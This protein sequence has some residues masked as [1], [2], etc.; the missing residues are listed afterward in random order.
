[1]RGRRSAAWALRVSW[2]RCA[3][4]AAKADCEPQA[5][6]LSPRTDV[7]SSHGHA[8]VTQGRVQPSVTDGA[9]SPE[10]LWRVP[11]PPAPSGLSLDSCSDRASSSAKSKAQSM[12]GGYRLLVCEVVCSLNCLCEPR[13][14]ACGVSWS[15]VATQDG[16]GEALHLA[17]SRRRDRRSRRLLSAGWTT[18]SSTF[19]GRLHHFP[20]PPAAES[21]VGRS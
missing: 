8:R 3:Q 9:A 16:K 5:G 19:R 17:R 14:N 20:Q 15:P 6:G 21:V 2:A 10:G 7:H 13:A 11:V 4:F 18:S 1:M 12:P